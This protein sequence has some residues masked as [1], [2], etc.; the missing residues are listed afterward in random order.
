M[1]IQLL[2][3][4]ID[5]LLVYGKRLLEENPEIIARRHIIQVDHHHDT[6]SDQLIQLIKQHFPIVNQHD[7]TFECKSKTNT[8]GFFMKPHV[9]DC[10]IVSNIKK[11]ENLEKYIQVNDTK[12]L[13]RRNNL[14]IYTVLYYCSQS[15]IDFTGGKLVFADGLQIEPVKGMFIFFDSREVHYV[16]PVKSGERTNWIVKMYE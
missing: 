14:P 8:K 11:T 7:C 10:Q 15:K 12:S 6:T 13:Y 4:N 16:T 5:S 2:M 9:D 1:P 3:A